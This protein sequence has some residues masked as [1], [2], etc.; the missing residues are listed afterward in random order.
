M[1]YVEQNLMPG[2]KVTYRATLHWIIYVVPVLLGVLGLILLL[3]PPFVGFG[4]GVLVVSGFLALSRWI[5]A[6]T[7][8]FAV[9][10]KR[11][12]IK[13]GLIRRHTLELLLSKVEIIGVDQ[14]MTGRIVGYGSIVVIGTGG[15]K[16]PF[17]NIAAPLE[18][19]KQVQAHAVA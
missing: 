6:R 12:I 16:E 18:F 1:G 15:T 7:S 11:V 3:S 9:T 8:E 19:R 14:G 13:V 4:V 2:E 5:T 10:N 17:K